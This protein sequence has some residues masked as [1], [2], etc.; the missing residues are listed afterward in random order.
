MKKVILWGIPSALTIYLVYFIIQNALD[1]PHADMWQFTDLAAGIQSLSWDYLWQQHNEHRVI[2][3]KLF[4]YVWARLT[5]WDFYLSSF[6]PGFFLIV[7]VFIVLLELK[8]K[9]AKK[10][11]VWLVLLFL[12]VSCLFLSLAHWDTILISFQMSW[13]STVILLI[14]FDL[15][16]RKFLSHDKHWLKLIVIITITAF[17]HAQG[18]VIGFYLTGYFLLSLLFKEKINKKFYLLLGTSIIITVAY[19][20][21][22]KM[23]NQGLDPFL[24]VKNPFEA[25]AY[26]G[27]FIGNA[28]AQTRNPYFV[29]IY[30]LFLIPSFSY[31]FYLNYKTS[32]LKSIIYLYRENPL[33]VLGA[34]IMLVVMVGRLENGIYQ[35]ASPR[36]VTFSLILNIGIWLYII[37]A[38]EKHRVPFKKH[39][40]TVFSLLGLFAYVIGM[41]GYYSGL[42][43]GLVYG[44]KKLM[45]NRRSYHDCILSH[46]N[47]YRKCDRWAHDVYPDNDYLYKKLDILKKHRLSLFK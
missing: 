19:L 39:L 6:I 11:F 24:F 27:G 18:L 44:G 17:I 30:L 2:W 3:Q 34:L 8:K 32:K 47:D 26:C 40:V 29:L 4:V 13:S 10:S 14:L 16:F 37:S 5:H 28:F 20:Y 33:I 25:I 23:G 45:D 1:L 43:G 7:S 35:A 31:S 22:Y 36:Y 42:S 38:W 21:N 15:Y 46:P 12:G 9:Y 41:T